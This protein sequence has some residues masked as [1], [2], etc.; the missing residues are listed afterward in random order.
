MFFI[1]IP[2]VLTVL[3]NLIEL[4]PDSKNQS[5]D[6]ILARILHWH[7]KWLQEQETQK[8]ASAAKLE[9]TKW[10]W[11]GDVYNRVVTCLEWRNKDASKKET[12]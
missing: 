4:S 7:T 11:T 5:Y 9:C 8:K 12:R 6:D 2:T 1:Q 3:I 10:A